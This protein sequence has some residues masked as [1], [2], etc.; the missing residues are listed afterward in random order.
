MIVAV[1]DLRFRYPRSDGDVLQGREIE[2]PVGLQRGEGAE[3]H[4]PVDG[5]I[6]AVE[7]DGYHGITAPRT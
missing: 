1:H 3:P 4:R 5:R 2:G 7:I 6:Q